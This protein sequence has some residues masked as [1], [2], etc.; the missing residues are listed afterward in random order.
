MN[1]GEGDFFSMQP[2]FAAFYIPKHDSHFF[3]TSSHLEG[4][5]G[6]GGKTFDRVLGLK[7]VRLLDDFATF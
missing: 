4:G 1:E 6:G 5:E 2:K 3:C 7:D